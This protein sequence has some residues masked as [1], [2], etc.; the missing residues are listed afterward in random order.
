MI[1]VLLA[2]MLQITMIIGSTV[3]EPPSVTPKEFLF[4]VSGMLL[5]GLSRGIRDGLQAPGETVARPGNVINADVANQVLG[6]LP[7]A[8]AF[9]V[10][11]GTAGGS[12]AGIW[13]GS[14]MGLLT[15]LAMPS[16]AF[17]RYFT[18][19]LWG[20]QELPVRLVKFLSC[21]QEIGL[22]RIS[23]NAYQF[24]HRE[25]QDWLANHPV[26]P[27]NSRDDELQESED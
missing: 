10:V 19:L 1:G 6:A 25:L 24:R 11:F 27:G 12:E 26:P 8:I 4:L 9:G 16:A 2:V 18:F 20:H 22:L 5:I 7:V 13:A 17:R 23:G 3:D 15:A 21:T 14:T